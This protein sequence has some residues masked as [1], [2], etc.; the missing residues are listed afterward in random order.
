MFINVHVSDNLKSRKMSKNDIIGKNLYS[1][2]C[3]NSQKGLFGGILTLAGT[4]LSLII[5]FELAFYQDRTQLALLQVNI[6]LGSY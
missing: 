2:D 5:F 1:M 3:G 6:Y 4:A